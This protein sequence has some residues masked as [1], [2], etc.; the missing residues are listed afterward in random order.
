LVR[1]LPGAKIPDRTDFKTFFRKDNDRFQ[2]WDR[3]V[4]MCRAPS[5]AFWELVVSGRIRDA[6]L[7]M[8][9]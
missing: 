9:F 8:P 2:A 1:Q 5:E 3:T 6:V 4:E 7:P